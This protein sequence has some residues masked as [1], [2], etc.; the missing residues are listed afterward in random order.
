MSNNVI[1]TK[2]YPN[3][4]KLYTLQVATFPE[5]EANLNRRF[6]ETTAS[7]YQFLEILAQ[8]IIQIIGTDV[9]KYCEDYKFITAIVLEEEIFFRRENRYRLSCFED[10]INKV[11]ADKV[12]MTRYMNGLLMS[13]LWWGNHTKVMQYF[14]AA[15]LD[16]NKPDFNHLEIGPGHGLFLYFAAMHPNCRNASGWDIS[17]ASLEL[18]RSTLSKLKCTNSVDL[19]LVNMFDAPT[20]QFDSIV[21]SEVLEH[22][23]KPKMA[24][25]I[26]HSLLAPGGRAFINAPVN[27][28]APDH[29]TLFRAPEE[30]VQMVEEAGFIVENTLFEP[31]AGSSLE[32]ARQRALAISTAVI[33]RK[34]G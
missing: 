18:V 25:E 8:K 3:L 29:I 15:F 26:I 6:K 20:G 31:T 32:R 12:Y 33:A 2:Y 19:S 13:Q 30:I 9:K 16:G 21:F 5:H 4:S 14:Q 10:A 34:K 28:P 11:Y 22:L 7:E 23:E 27:S 1:D 17:E 24:L